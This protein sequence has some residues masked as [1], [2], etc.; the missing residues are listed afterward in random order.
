MTEYQSSI[1]NLTA[2]GNPRPLDYIWY[3]NADILKLKSARRKRAIEIPYFLAMNG[4]MNLTNVTRGDAG[5]YTVE[6]RNSEGSTNFT[7]VLNV[8]CKF[9]A[10]TYYS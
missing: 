10:L 1:L 7:F 6:A 8:Q 4:V 5:N 3:K 9:K 2:L